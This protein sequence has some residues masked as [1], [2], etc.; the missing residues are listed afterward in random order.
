MA[1]RQGHLESFKNAGSWGRLFRSRAKLIA[2]SNKIRVLVPGSPFFE[3]GVACNCVV[4]ELYNNLQIPAVSK[5]KGVKN[6]AQAIK[7][8]ASSG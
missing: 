2:A 8:A 5:E 6:T 4:W 7:R 3:D 1:R